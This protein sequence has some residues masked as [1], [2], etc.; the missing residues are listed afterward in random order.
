MKKIVTI[1]CIWVVFLFFI[2]KAST[3]FLKNMTSYEVYFPQVTMPMRPVFMPWL[4][5]DGRNYFAIVMDGYRDDYFKN[6]KLANVDEKRVFFPLYP[7]IIRALSLDRHIN[8]IFVGLGVSYV[9]LLGSLFILY[10]LVQKDFDNK[11]AIKTVLLLLLFP[12]SYYFLAYY[13]ESF[14]LFLSLLMFWFLR[15]KNFL[16][17]SAVCA[18]ATA[19][20]MIGVSLIIPLLYEAYLYYKKT[21]KISFMRK[22]SRILFG[23]ELK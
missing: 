12:T 9:S 18:L 13:T 14:F 21:K 1:F 2:N 23:Y 5:Y 3:Y 17:A 6:G 20:R 4:N 22:S 8:P 16:A 7:L 19:T 15:K 11:K 10:D